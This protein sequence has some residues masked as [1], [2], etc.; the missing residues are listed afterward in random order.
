MVYIGLVSKV[1]RN[2]MG[3][4][5]LAKYKQQGGCFLKS[6]EVVESHN[7]GSHLFFPV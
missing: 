6:L 1:F 4:K 7:T 2:S 3:K 5:K